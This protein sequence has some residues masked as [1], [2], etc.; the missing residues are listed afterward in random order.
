MRETF[1]D[2][3]ANMQAMADHPE[4]LGN[5]TAAIELLHDAFAR[6]HKLLV[7]GNGGSAADAEHLA[8]EFVCRFAYDRP[9]VAA[10]ALATNTALLT[11]TS[12]D[13]TFDEVFARQIDALGRPG[14]VAWGLSTSGKSPNVLRGLER[15]RAR[16]MRTIGLCGADA[17]AMR[18][19]CD[20]LLAVPLAVTARIQEVHLVTGHII[21][22]A[23]ES[24]LF[25]RT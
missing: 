24:R 19:W 2:V 18:E 8:T 22:G 20:V 4:Y 5:V 1:L 14:D 21:C 9:A 10:I 23:V 7:F 17:T 11:A 25:P 13:L 15:A 6:Q 3:A 16:G 12:N